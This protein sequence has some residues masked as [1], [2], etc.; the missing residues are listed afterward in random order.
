MFEYSF[1]I[2]LL[3]PLVAALLLLACNRSID[4]FYRQKVAEGVVD[5]RALFL[6]VC[7]AMVSITVILSMAF[8]IPLSLAEGGLE[9]LFFLVV[10]SVIWSC[11]FGGLLGCMVGT[12]AALG[13]R[14]NQGLAKFYALTTVILCGLAAFVL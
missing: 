10:G 11:L 12:A 8:S 5:R 13:P 3:I 4:S 7:K 9:S 2:V 1:L 14:K 6:H